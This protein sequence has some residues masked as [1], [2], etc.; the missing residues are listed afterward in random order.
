M[1][2]SSGWI[3]VGNESSFCIIQDVFL[4]KLTSSGEGASTVSL[5]G[6]CTATVCRGKT[7]LAFGSDWQEL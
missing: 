2:I 3:L 7:I 5:T 1:V 6:V 4:G